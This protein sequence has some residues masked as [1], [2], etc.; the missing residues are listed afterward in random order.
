MWK[1][2]V[3]GLRVLIT[4]Y[5]FGSLKFCLMWKEWK[6]DN[7]KCKNYED[8]ICEKN[9][10]KKINFLKRMIEEHKKSQK[11]D[12]KKNGQIKLL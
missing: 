1:C 8:K 7:K 5:H 6:L 4:L 10:S 12:D 3:C 11:N 9:D 2:N